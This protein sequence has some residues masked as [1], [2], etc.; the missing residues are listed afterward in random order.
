[1]K[2]LKR[3][4]VGVIAIVAVG[5]A[6]IAVAL[7]IRPD[8][9]EYAARELPP[10]PAPGTP[11][12]PVLRVT[13]LGVST[14]L[15]DDGETA[16]MTDAFFSR[17]GVLQ[18][19]T[20]KI[21]PDSEVI[22][23]ALD[24]AGV[25]SLA[26]IIPVHSHYDHVMDAPVVAQRTGALLVGSASTANVGR[27]MGL[28]EERIKVVQNGEVLTFGRFRITLF[29]SAHAP[30]PMLMPGEIT[31][32]LTPPAKFNAYRLGECYSV[33]VEHDGRAILV[34]GSAGFVPGALQ[35][36]K[37]DVVYLG[38]ALIGRQGEEFRETYWREVV[39]GPGARRVIPVH[40]D[41]FFVSLDKPLV[42]LPK[43]S[44]D[45]GATMRYLLQREAEGGPEVRMSAPWIA[46]D[47]FAGMAR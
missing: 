28:P 26:A 38:I 39:E 13:F 9:S 5:I 12:A 41:D 1:M 8:L 11:D 44:D 6:A 47:P 23:R 3:L 27:G 45:V 17:P 2:W 25:R 33:L 37:A 36:V 43:L 22:T 10:A 31:S 42:A 40:W 21:A 20:G 24:R 34:Q 15:F 35:G 46:S 30:S 14:L 4:L 16:F 32:P 19:L 7:N 18:M 29:T